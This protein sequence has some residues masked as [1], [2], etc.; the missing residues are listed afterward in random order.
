MRS[1]SAWY[2]Q[3]GNEDARGTNDKNG[4]VKL[5]VKGA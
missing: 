2:D 1:P 3:D 5:T 4:K